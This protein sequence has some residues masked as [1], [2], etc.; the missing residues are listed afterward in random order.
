[1][2]S[3]DKIKN[4]I[5][6]IEKTKLCKE[7]I[8]NGLKIKWETDFEKMQFEKLKSYDSLNNCFNYEILRVEEYDLTSHYDSDIFIGDSQSHIDMIG[9]L[10][11]GGKLIPPTK[12]EG[13]AIVDGEEKMVRSSEM[14]GLND[15]THRCNLAKY[16]GLDIIPVVVFKELDGYW[17]TPEEW[18]F[19]GGRIR[20]ENKTEFGSSFLEFNGF[21]ATSKTGKMYTFQDP[22][23]IDE[24][25]SDYIVIR[26]H[27][28]SVK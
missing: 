2:N 27:A 1:M 6:F 22:I 26:N 17:F 15:G 12:T 21:K 10:I 3:I 16:L 14:T 24:T 20:E 28:Y 9:I 25:I 13:Y 23:I 11:K 19:E 5:E 7:A 4:R 18:T 8:K